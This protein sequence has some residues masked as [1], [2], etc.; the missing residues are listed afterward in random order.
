MSLW[1]EELWDFSIDVKPSDFENGK[2]SADGRPKL[3]S[4]PSIPISPVRNNLELPISL[5]QLFMDFFFNPKDVSKCVPQFLHY[6]SSFTHLTLKGLIWVIVH[7]IFYQALNPP[8]IQLFWET[9]RSPTQKPFW[10]TFIDYIAGIFFC[11]APKRRRIQ[12][13]VA[14]GYHNTS[15]TL[16]STRPVLLTK[17]CFGKQ[18]SLLHD[19]IFWKVYFP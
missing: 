3:C 16:W 19:Q 8:N 6:A 4:S 17:P 9:S 7:R 12:P 11:L 2:T 10:F 15:P 18:V 14:L 13:D 1:S 5:P